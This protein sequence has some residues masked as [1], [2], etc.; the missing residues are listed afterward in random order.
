MKSIHDVLDELRLASFDERHKGDLFEAL[1]KK[2]LEIDPFYGTYFDKVWLYGDWATQS[3]L[4]KQ[5]TGIDLVARI[6]ETGEIAAIQ[7]KFYAEGA[8]LDKKEIDSFFTASGK[9]PFRERYIFSTTDN[10]LFIN[11]S[12]LNA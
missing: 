11:I 2:F 5:D 7:C 4:S 10:R 9:E 3:N 12:S 1:T 6:A 8:Y